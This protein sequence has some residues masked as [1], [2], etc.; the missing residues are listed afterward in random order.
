MLV[1][2]ELKAT[3][4]GPEQVQQLVEACRQWPKGPVDADF[5]A[6]FTSTAAALLLSGSEDPVTPPGYAVQAQRAFADSKHVVVA[7]HGHGQLTT[8]CVD[9]MIATF[10]HA[11]TTKTLDTSC[12]DK[13]SPMPF[14]TTL[15]GPAP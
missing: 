4:M 5:H 1:L 8:P 11:G 14:F 10:I 9:R 12:T 13:V 7:G 2:E 15:A 6:P 3:H